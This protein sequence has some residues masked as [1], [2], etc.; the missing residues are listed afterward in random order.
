MLDQY[1]S[2]IELSDYYINGQGQGGAGAGD[3]PTTLKF[4]TRKLARSTECYQMNT[5]LRGYTLY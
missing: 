3:L 1:D 5:H 4:E 2:V